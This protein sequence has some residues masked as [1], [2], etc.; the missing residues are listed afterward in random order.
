[1]DTECPGKRNVRKLDSLLVRCPKCSQVVEIFT[2]EMKARCRCG[3]VLL[4]ESVPACISWCASA[5][6]CL[7]EV[8]DLRLIRQR[9]EAAHG[10]GS[11]DDY[12]KEIGKKVAESQHCGDD[13]GKDSPKKTEQKP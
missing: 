13:A 2:D 9:I 8:I 1:M 6:R 11:A 10:P 3:E 12:V 5:E 7:G 4:R